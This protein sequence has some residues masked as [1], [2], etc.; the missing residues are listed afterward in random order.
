[1][2]SEPSTD[3]SVYYQRVTATSA[4][5]TSVHYHDWLEIYLLES[6]ECHYFI[7]ERIYSVLAGDIVLIPPG[8]LHKTNYLSALHSRTL[9]GCPVSCIPTPLRAHLSDREHILRGAREDKELSEVME[10]IARECKT[11]G[12]YADT[13]LSLCVGYLLTL[14][15]RRLP[16]DGDIGSRPSYTESAIRYIRE[17]YGESITLSEVARHCAVSDAHLSRRF[18]QDTGVNFAEYLKVYRLNQAEKM[19]RRNPHLSISEVAYACGFNDSNYFSGVFK[20]VYGVSPI[21]KR[22][23]LCAKSKF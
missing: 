16:A 3:A 6:G 13:A 12:E 11:E 22:K 15:V 19:L 5:R 10:R 23:E 21:K 18:K 9:I 2:L 14:L 20:R 4:S 17:N 1:M 7:G 8:E